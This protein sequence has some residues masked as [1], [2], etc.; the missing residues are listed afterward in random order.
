MDMRPDIRDLKRDFDED[1]VGDVPYELRSLSTA[2]ISR[3][4]DLSFFRGSASLS[5]VSAVGEMVPLLAPHPV[6]R[7]EHPR[8]RALPFEVPH[9]D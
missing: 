5:L 6:L 9:A 3:Y 2:L 8:M 4:P 1:G 7:D